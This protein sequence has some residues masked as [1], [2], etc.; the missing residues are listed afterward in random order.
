MSAQRA[1]NYAANCSRAGGAPRDIASVISE[2]RTFRRVTDGAPALPPAGLGDRP[3]AG[4]S[5]NSR[6]VLSDSPNH[7][8]HLG[9]PDLVATAI[10]DVVRCR[11]VRCAARGRG[12]GRLRR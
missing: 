10:G 1:R 4:L 8:L 2:W 7:Y 6:H 5:V 3:L 11:Q 9:D 12:A